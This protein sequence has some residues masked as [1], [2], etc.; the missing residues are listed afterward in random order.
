MTPWYRDYLR[1]WWRL[2]HGETVVVMEIWY[3]HR[4]TEL[5]G[6]LDVP[7]DEWNECEAWAVAISEPVL[8]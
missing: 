4:Y 5:A 6:R 2:L 7:Y 3:G 1:I 8:P